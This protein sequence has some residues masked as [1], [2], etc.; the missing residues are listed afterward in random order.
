MRFLIHLLFILYVTSACSPK[1]ET[2]D[3]EKEIIFDIQKRQQASVDNKGSILFGD[4][5]SGGKEKSGGVVNFGTSNVLW[6]ATLKTLDFI[7]LSSVD[8]GGGLVVTDWYSEPGKSNEQIKIQ[9]RFLSNEVRSDSIEIKSFKKICIT[10]VNCGNTSLSENFNNE[11]KNSI[12][13][14]ARI[15]KIE[16]ER[17]KK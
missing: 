8:Y 17:K 14:T 10:N 4:L 13:N 5:F 11:I 2:V 12:L 7:P 15:I 1:K 6:R 3:S 16:E 9:I